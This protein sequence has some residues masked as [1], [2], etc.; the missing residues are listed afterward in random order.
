MRSIF[1]AVTLGVAALPGEAAVIT[2]HS[3][4]AR[5]TTAASGCAD[6]LASTQPNRRSGERVCDA[7]AGEASGPVLGGA[8]I[9][10]SAGLQDGG[11]PWHA[12]A[13][14]GPDGGGYGVL[15]VARTESASGSFERCGARPCDVDTASATAAA[16]WRAEFTVDGG[17][18]GFRIVPDLYGSTP[19]TL[20]LEDLTTGL[21]LDR[22]S[23]AV[24][25][26]GRRYALEFAMT[27]PGT[28]CVRT[29][30]ALTTFLF[31]DAT[32]VYESPPPR[33]AVPEPA[34]LGLMGAALFAAF[35]RR[36][37]GG[38]RPGRATA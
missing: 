19:W 2:V 32:F 9:A 15:L 23:S 18:A 31:A 35:A 29:C 34:S 21:V 36:R 3:D 13:S 28:P 16:L 22:P 33:M 10:A 26:P 30:A 37:R 20:R 14:F 17:A 24:L 8:P 12:R 4:V 5:L 6:L 25:S 11:Y 7:L 1:V 38:V 27:Q